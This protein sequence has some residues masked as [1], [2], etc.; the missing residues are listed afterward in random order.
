MNSLA[1]SL[2]R[3]SCA[4]LVLTSLLSACSA[5]PRA[6]DGDPPRD[7]EADH[8][9]PSNPENLSW[10]WYPLD[11]QPV[12]TVESGETVRIE[13]LTHAGTTQSEEP[14]AYLTAFGVPR[15][16]ILPDVVDF[17]RSREGREREGRSGHVITGPIYVEGA[18]PGDV[19]EVQIL[20]LEVRVP[21]GINNTGPASGVFGNAY[22]GARPGDPPLDIAPG[23]RHLIRT[24]ETEGQAVAFFSAGIQVPLA[25][26]M[27][28]LAVAPAGPVVGEPGV[29]VPGVQA[30]RP[31]GPF[32]G[33]LDVK[34]LV[35][36]TRL[37]LPVF[38]P[39]ALFYTGDPHSA[40]GDGEVSGT[41]IEQSLTGVFRFVLH[42]GESIQGP[43]AESDT[44]YLLM[45]IDLDLDR[46]MRNATRAV[47]EFLVD[48]KDLTPAEALSLASIA[49]DFHVA[50]VVDLTQVVV[51]HIPK[52]LFLTP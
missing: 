37:F 38:H 23:T 26:F 25:P 42:K 24:G 15:E 14:V 4:A 6:G 12:L 31:P 5:P 3:V 33:N 52:S 17:W 30:S 21:W 13:T 28:I 36:G 10:G 18:E 47:V 34:D 9:V 39:G 45:G 7:I 48:E 49:V 19:L 22:P 40:Q 8:L 16:E 32:G 43:R 29:T 20:E 35:A 44:H 1:P 2:A 41:A 50:E 11:K 46:A 27:G 51:G